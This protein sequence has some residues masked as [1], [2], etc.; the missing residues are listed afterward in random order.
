M[1]VA[2]VLS[3][4]FDLAPNGESKRLDYGRFLGYHK[5]KIKK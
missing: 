5:I 4:S 1:L 2:S 3:V